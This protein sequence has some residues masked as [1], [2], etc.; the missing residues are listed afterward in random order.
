MN[1]PRAIAL[2]KTFA[3]TLEFQT[4]NWDIAEATLREAI[5]LYR[6]IGSASGEA[7]ACHRLAILLNSSGRI[8]EAFAILQTGRIAADHALMRAH[9]LTRI[10]AVI[11]GNRLVAG[12]L[13]AAEDALESG[14]T[15][16]DRHG[17]CATCDSFLL[18]VAVSVRIAQGN[19]VEAAV[20]CDR[21]Q[22]EAEQYGGQIWMAITWLSRAELATAQGNFDNAIGWYDAAYRAFMDVGHKFE[23][24]RSLMALTDVY[25]KRST[26]DDELKAQDSNQQAQA[27]LKGLG[28]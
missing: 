9:C 8:E 3:G 6:E 7:L 16:S 19:L 1:A 13:T 18:P 11:A 4:G 12:D 2:C 5:R 22:H 21:I 17:N 10:Y 15:M 24:A 14:L 23:A 20:F 27:I 28:L 25:Q 26:A